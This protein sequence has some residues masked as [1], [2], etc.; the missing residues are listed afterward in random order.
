[1]EKKTS[2]VLSSADRKLSVMKGIIKISFFIYPPSRLKNS[3][4]KV[5]INKIFLF[6]FYP[7]LGGKILC[8]RPGSSFLYGKL[9]RCGAAWESNPIS[10][11]QN[12]G[13]SDPDIENILITI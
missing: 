2:D 4:R 10:L 11:T 1:M 13:S 6:L 9:Y 8:D 12:P 5:E 7:P 3:E